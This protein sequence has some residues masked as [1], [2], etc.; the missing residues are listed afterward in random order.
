MADCVRGGVWGVTGAA[1]FLKEKKSVDENGERRNSL[2]GQQ[3]VTR[4]FI[5]GRGGPSSVDRAAR[6]HTETQSNSRQT[7]DICCGHNQCFRLLAQI[8]EYTKKAIK[9]QF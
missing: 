2:G 8:H 4:S 9:R 7:E 1:F 6:K 5:Q 3:T